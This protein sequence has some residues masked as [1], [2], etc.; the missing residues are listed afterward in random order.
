MY[1]ILEVPE[2][3]G[4]LDTL[5]SLFYSLA[6]DVPIGV[7]NKALES[8]LPHDTR[9]YRDP[10]LAA[11]AE[12]YA[13]AICANRLPFIADSIKQLEVAAPVRGAINPSGTLV[14]SS[15][16]GPTPTNPERICGTC[17][18]ADTDCREAPCDTCEKLS[19]GRVGTQMSNWTPWSGVTPKE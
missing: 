3:A 17:K 10:A 14:I 6:K 8:A 7:L 18:Y 12:Q 11:W 2:V 9:T 13:W 5:K 16:T 1:K 19:Q 4:I 15:P